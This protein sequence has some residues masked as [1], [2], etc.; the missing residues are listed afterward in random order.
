MYLNPVTDDE[1]I[2]TVGQCKNEPSVDFSNLSMTVIKRIIK[3]VVRLFEHICNLSFK[4]GVVPDLMKIAKIIPLF[5][6]G[7]KQLFT[8]Y[9]P[10]AIL[11]QLSKIL[12]KLFCKRLNAF[13]DK[14][15]I[16]NDRQYGFR[17]NRSTSNALLELVEE[18][19]TANDNNR[20][21]VVS[22]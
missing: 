3:S 9:R 18:I 2:N 17:A 16:L 1:I 5:K 10:V 4:T 7:D 14:H 15:N 8:N 22:L 20:Y 19:I 11:P 12:E 6:S 13:I 21:T